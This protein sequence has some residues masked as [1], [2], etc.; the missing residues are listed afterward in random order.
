[1][2]GE[3]AYLSVVVSGWATVWGGG[4]MVVGR[5]EIVGWSAGVCMYHLHP[6]W[7]LVFLGVDIQRNF[8]VI[9]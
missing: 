3:E 8:P 2:Q 4:G 9:S 7:R 5:G 1:M 6:N